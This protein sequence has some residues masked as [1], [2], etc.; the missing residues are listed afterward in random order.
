MRAIPWDHTLE[1][2]VAEM[3]GEHRAIVWRMNLLIAEMGRGV[4]ER[5]IVARTEDLALFTARH[6]AHEEASMRAHGYHGLNVHKAEH[7]HL[8]AQLDAVSDRLATDGMAAVDDALIEFLHHW[9]VHH[10]V[11]MDR[12]FAHFLEHGEAGFG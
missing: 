2:G 10:V 5:Q 1:L 11:T 6:F 7:D 12:A 3:D 9:V 4:D 8:L